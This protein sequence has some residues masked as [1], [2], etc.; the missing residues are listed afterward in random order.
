MHYLQEYYCKSAEIEGKPV[1]K[2][3]K[4]KIRLL[5][6]LSHDVESKS[7]LWDLRPMWQKLEIAH[8]HRLALPAQRPA[9][10][11]GRQPRESDID[12]VSR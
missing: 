10:S 2:Y 12:R 9:V 4:G 3:E 6:G 8:E 1:T 11:A 5:N 7:N